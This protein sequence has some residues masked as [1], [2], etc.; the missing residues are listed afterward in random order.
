MLFPDRR[1]YRPVGVL[2]SSLILRHNLS[3]D[4]LVSAF[5]GYSGISNTILIIVCLAGS[6]VTEVLLLGRFR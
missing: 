5:H 6:K 1:D 3:N 2:T 4:A